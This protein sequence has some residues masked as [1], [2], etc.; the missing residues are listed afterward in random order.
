MN[1][2]QLLALVGVLQIP[3]AVL[4]LVTYNDAAAALGRWVD[5]NVYLGVAIGFCYVISEVIVNWAYL[6]TVEVF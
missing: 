5:L 6:S 3:F 2:A 1:A 4:V